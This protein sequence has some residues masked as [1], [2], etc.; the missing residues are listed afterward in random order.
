MDPEENPLS[1]NFGVRI[2]ASIVNLAKLLFLLRRFPI[3]EIRGPVINL[4]GRYQKQSSL[5][6]IHRHRSISFMAI[7]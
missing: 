7:F 1:T 2:P 6:F 3:K 4:V 5:V